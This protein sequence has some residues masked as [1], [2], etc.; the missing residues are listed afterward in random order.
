MSL[1]I[2]YNMLPVPLAEDFSSAGQGFFKKSGSQTDK[3]VCG[4][5]EHV[6]LFESFWTNG[7]GRDKE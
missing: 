4:F 3:D 6:A 2:Q 5:L 1:L 7:N